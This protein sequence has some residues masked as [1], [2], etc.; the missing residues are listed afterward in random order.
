MFVLAL[1]VT[2]DAQQLP[3]TRGLHALELEVPGA[4]KV[5]YAVAVP[6]GY[7][8]STPVPLV[9]VLH[10]GGQRSRYYGGEF[11]RRVVEPA[12]RGLKAIMIAPDCSGRDWSDASCEKPVL[13]LIELA[14]RGY[15]IDR[16]RVL[17]VGYSMGGRGTWHMASKHPGIF[18]AAIPMAASTRGMAVDQLGR[19]PTYVIHSREDE[20]VAF[21]P[22]EENAAALKKL[23]RDV[24]FEALDE[25]THFD[26]LSYFDALER[27]GRWVA[28]RWKQ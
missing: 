21:E 16:Q 12:L 11:M 17:V 24:E 23:K 13:E 22:A 15:N 28:G 8:S 19:Q 27:A 1:G 18:T 25:F 6:E 14:T 10:P 7:R 26:M 5:L 3:Q 9:I 4:S 2:L 20:V